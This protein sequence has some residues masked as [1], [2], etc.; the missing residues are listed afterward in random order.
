[1][2]IYSDAALEAELTCGMRGYERRAQILLTVPEEMR[3][4]IVADAHRIMNNI[5]GR[6]TEALLMAVRSAKVGA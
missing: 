2:N 3:S 1:M 6:A 5:G 4:E